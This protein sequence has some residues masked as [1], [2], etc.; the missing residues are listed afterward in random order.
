MHYAEDRTL[1]V[2]EMAAL[3]SFP[4][5]YKLFG[6]MTAQRRQ[7]GNAV[8]VELATAVA[9]S[10]RQSLLYHYKADD[11]TIMILIK[12]G[13]RIYKVLFFMVVRHWQHLSWL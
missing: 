9:R 2:N 8:P 11:G 4:V 3:Q 12:A 1:S 13:I 7:I 10:G 6:S 5:G